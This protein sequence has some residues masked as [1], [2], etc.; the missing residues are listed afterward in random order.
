MGS[1]E[2]GKMGEEEQGEGRLTGRKADLLRMPAVCPWN[3]LLRRDPF[4]G[5]RS[6]EPT[7][8]ASGLLGE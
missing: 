8:T 5:L 4:L 7:V 2:T 1:R 6:E 3:R